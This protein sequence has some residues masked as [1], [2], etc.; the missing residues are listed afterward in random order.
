MSVFLERNHMVLRAPDGSDG[1]VAAMAAAGF[2][3]VYCNV[4]D[5]PAEAWQ[6]IRDRA[7][8][9]GVECGPWAR[10]ATGTTWDE[11]MLQELVSIADAW[12]SSLIVNSEKELDGS[13]DTLTRH[14]ADVLGARDY[15][16]SVEAWPFGATDWTPF[17]TVPVIPQIFPAESEPSK[18]PEGCRTEW[19]RRG[20]RCVV[21]CF[22]S[23]AG[24]TPEL[25]ELHSPFGIYTADDC[26]GQYQRWAPTGSH[27]PCT[28]EPEPEPEP[29]D[30]MEPVTD[31]QARTAIEFAVQAA[32]QNWG[33]ETKPRARL[34]VCR[35]IAQAGN[36]DAKW[37]AVRDEI[38]S[39]LDEAGIPA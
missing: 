9:A 25:Y 15:A 1:N 10:T 28:P 6:T 22:G 24:Q 14:I 17:E 3:A 18:D 2:G 31:T 33:T 37:N 27:D 34:T 20:V 11:A 5:F 29:E 7:Y 26:G 16:M 30:E 4:R 35:R 38:V 39:L 13:G 32:A 8:S 12:D 36:S 19:H 23:Y 21:F